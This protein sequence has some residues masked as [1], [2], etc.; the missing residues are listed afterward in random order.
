MMRMYRWIGVGLVVAGAMFAERRMAVNRA[1]ANGWDTAL[2]TLAAVAPVATERVKV[3]TERTD[4]SAAQVSRRAPTVRRAAVALIAQLDSTPN[5]ALPDTA[6]LPVLQACVALA[7]DCEALR[8]NVLTERASRDSLTRSLQAINVATQDTL[9]RY[10]KRPTRRKAI[11]LSVLAAGA[12]YLLG[13][14]DE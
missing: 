12:G 14:Q 8:A 10:A 13:R 5:V 3:A 2:R 9:Q 6:V 4:S 1:Y 11:L 7:N